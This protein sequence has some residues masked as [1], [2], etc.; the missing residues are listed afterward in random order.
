M[1]ALVLA[2]LLLPS[3]AWA[4]GLG[5]LSV[6]SALGQPL[7]AEI[8]VSSLESDEAISLTARLAAAE[9]YREANI[10]RQAAAMSIRF[11]VDKRPNGQ[12]VVLM[13]T[14]EPM[15]EP[16]LD[17][18]VELSW[19]NGRF[20]REY[21][22]LLDPV[23]YKAPVVAVPAATPP[24]VVPAVPVAPVAQPAPAPAATEP[25][26]R[27]PPAVTERPL[28]PPA[29]PAKPAVTAKPAATYEVKRGDTL[30]KIANQNKFEG[31]SVQQMLV[32][33]YRGNQDVFDG[34][35][36]SRLRA[37]KILNIPEREAAAGVSQEDA[38]RIVAA[39]NASYDEYRRQIG[40]AVA[41]APERA[42]GGRQAS[43]RIGAPREAAPPPPEAAKDQLRLSKARDAKAAGRAGAAARADDLAAKE[44]ALKEANE[45]IAMLEKNVQDLQKLAQLK[46]EV[47]AQMQQAAKGAPAKAAPEPAAK[48]AAMPDAAK[49]APPAPKVPEPAKAAPVPAPAKEEAKAAE[50]AAQAPK[51]PPA[52]AP[53]AAPKPVPAP[54]EPSFIDELLDN[55]MALGGAGGVVILLAAYAVYAWRTKRKSQFE[56]SM[57]GAA[58]QASPSVF[59]ASGGQ[60]I[61]T[62]GAAFQSDFSQGGIGKIDTEEIDPIA[63]ADVYMAYG[64]DT[65]AEEI[66]KDAIAKD[67]SRHEIRAKLLE[68]YANRKDLK[69]FET[70]ASELYAATSGQGPEWE[71]ALGLGLSIDP[72]NPLYGGAPAAAVEDTQVLTQE[73]LAA[74]APVATDAAGESP[75]QAAPRLDFDL[76][77]GEAPEQA[78]VK[79]DIPPIATVTPAAES[80]TTLDFD[81][82]L[83]DEQ[84]GEPEKG[85]AA[86]GV[87]LT[88]E[89]PKSEAAAPEADSDS[90]LSIDFDLGSTEAA[91]PAPAAEPAAA[92][93][94]G[95]TMDFDLGAPSEEEAKPAEEQLLELDLSAISLDLGAP[96]EAAPETGAAVP[97][98]DAHWQ[99]VATKL[100]LAKAYD[101]MGDKDGARELLNEVAKEG[102]AAQKQQAKTMLEALG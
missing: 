84:A 55:P 102:D 99:E 75:A 18:L 93:D 77:L 81:L 11:I 79:F 20:V 96:P 34:G 89:A 58:S 16:F 97:V 15:N 14:V 65:Q 27:A 10:E 53:K 72:H 69:A 100:D 83:G 43:G 74:V 90:G 42:A 38:L 13:T 35:N 63:E 36:M 60:Q 50:P 85:Q 28:A 49:A 62:G 24:V 52:A 101:E 48:A 70:T 41:Q 5:K 12:H 82:G 94:M 2:V 17:L 80:P 29:A 86:P 8:E 1:K 32:A 23:E 87:T 76:D 4:A 68:V 25:A 30:T 66:L 33:L 91:A 95:I 92:A 21:T 3:L 44:K 73:E 98:P 57:M 51:A 9:A 61:D 6:F 59:G 26:V 56:S 54:P 71:K 37:G 39:Q 88:A 7:R 46:S 40:A 67:S 31:V 47:G 45:R 78:T 19:A 22:F 64:R